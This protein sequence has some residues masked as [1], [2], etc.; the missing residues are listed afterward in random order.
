MDNRDLSLLSL[1]NAATPMQSAPLAFA[2]PP[3]RERWN[4]LLKIS[5]ME[6][7]NTA[8]GR[9]APDSNWLDILGAALAGANDVLAPRG[10]V[11]REAQSIL[12][13]HLLAERVIAIGFEPPRV[14][15]SVPTLI[16]TYV[17]KSYVHWDT[18]EISFGSLKFLDV[19]IISQSRAE[20]IREATRATEKLAIPAPKASQGRPTIYPHVK[21]A[22]DA[23]ESTGRINIRSSARSH[24][25]EIRQWISANTSCD[26][27]SLS[28][29]GIRAHFSPLFKSLK[30]SRKQ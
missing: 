6:Q 23:L 18:S 13:G 26:A 8:L 7:A 19:R 1:W 12:I 20:T 11:L 24:Y 4:E 29:E 15:K 21:A 9:V 22:F 27:D 10:E 3:L 5:A 28:D 17:W 2:P 14:L 16:P 25:D 30:N